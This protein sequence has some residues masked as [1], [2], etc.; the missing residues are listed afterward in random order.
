[1]TIKSPSIKLDNLTKNYDNLLAVNNVNLKIN[2]GEIFGLLGPNGAGKTTLI[3]MLVTLLKP[4]AGNAKVAGF[5]IEQE[6]DEI[7]KRIGVVF[8]NTILED[9]LTAWETLNIFARLYNIPKQIRRAKINKFLQLIY[10]E[11]RKNDL[12]KTYSGGMKRRLELIKGVLHEPEILF[13]D[14]PTLGLDPQSREFIW[15]YIRTLSIEMNVT[16]FLT[17]HYMEEADLLCDRIALIDHGKIV[18]LGN[19]TELKR[20][21]SS[22]N[23][24]EVKFNNRSINYLSA[25]KDLSFVKEVSYEKNIL[26]IIVNNTENAIF[27][28]IEELNNHKAE[29]TSVVLQEPTLNDVFLHYT[30]REIRE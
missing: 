25:I 14:E 3:R 27:Q 24:I 20:K 9:D 23:V 10:L 7:R 22:K 30:G 4:T 1:M 19:P 6:D 26:K 15:N 16:I 5:D 29:I 11:E 28:I 2:Q 17:T 18:A 12:V 13:L 21:L 8:Q